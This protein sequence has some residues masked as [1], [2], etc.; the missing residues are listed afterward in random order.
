MILINIIRCLSRCISVIVNS[1]SA[2]CIRFG[3]KRSYEIVIVCPRTRYM[4]LY[5][6]LSK[7][8]C[9]KFD[10]EVILFHFVTFV[11]ADN[12]TLRIAYRFISN[13]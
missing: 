11:T 2:L 5:R 7:S 3:N 1:F 4:F 13:L 10:N 8:G 6:N 9:I 12:S